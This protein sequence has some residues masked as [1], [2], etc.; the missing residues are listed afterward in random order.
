MVVQKYIE[1]DIIYISILEQPLD[2]H[3]HNCLLWPNNKPLTKVSSL[4]KKFVVQPSM[5]TLAVDK[6]SGYYGAKLTL[7]P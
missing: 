7:L 1:C 6:P 4:R 3:G 2:Q 5:A